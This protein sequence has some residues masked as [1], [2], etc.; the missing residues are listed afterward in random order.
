MGGSGSESEREFRYALARL[1]WAARTGRDVAGEVPFLVANIADRAAEREK[2]G[3]GTRAA[4]V[5]YAEATVRRA[6]EWHRNS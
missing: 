4:C 5:Q 6:L 1:S 3:H 2:R